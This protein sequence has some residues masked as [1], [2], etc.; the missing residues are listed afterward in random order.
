VSSGRKTGSQ[1][2]PRFSKNSYPIPSGSAVTITRPIKSARPSLKGG[3][4]SEDLHLETTATLTM[5]GQK[6]NEHIS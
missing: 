4:A 1:S 6:R 2:S 3:R 5:R